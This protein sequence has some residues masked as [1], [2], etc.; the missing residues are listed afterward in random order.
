LTPFVDDSISIPPF[1]PR[2]AK[3]ATLDLRN[4]ALPTYGPIDSSAVKTLVA[5]N[6]LVVLAEAK[7]QTYTMSLAVNL[8]TILVALGAVIEMGSDDRLVA[9]VAK[10]YELAQA[11]C[12]G[13]V[14]VVVRDIGRIGYIRMV[15]KTLGSLW[16]SDPRFGTCLGKAVQAVSAVAPGLPAAREVE[17]KLSN[18]TSTILTPVH[19]HPVN[20]E[21]PR[22]GAITAGRGSSARSPKQRF[23]LH[24]LGISW[25]KCML[26]CPC[27]LQIPHTNAP[28][29]LRSPTDR[30]R[31][32]VAHAV[33]L[34]A[35][36]WSIRRRCGGGTSRRSQR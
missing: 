34:A 15:Y 13:R 4:G 36:A 11:E 30:H 33:P 5:A 29:E 28:C 20:R 1:C 31:D 12:E 2:A 14:V 6:S 16:I 17:H 7:Y 18:G 24:S 3:P 35:S 21:Y 22:R 23:G 9:D 26:E 27:G 32:R 25:G 19:A 8:F 10:T